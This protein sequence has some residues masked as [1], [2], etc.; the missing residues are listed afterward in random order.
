MKWVHELTFEYTRSRGPGGQNV[1]K[2]NSAALLRWHVDSSNVFSPED[3]VTIHQKL[4]NIINSEGYLLLRSDS[5]RDQEQNRKACIERLDYL[6][7]RALFKPKKRIKTKPTKSS[8]RKRVDAKKS[9]GEIKKNRRR[10]D[11]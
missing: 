5:F 6:L 2:T 7:K 9:R 4:S 10:V 1:N 3:K 8:V 11:Y